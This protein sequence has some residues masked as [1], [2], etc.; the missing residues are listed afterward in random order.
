[1]EDRGVSIIALQEAFERVRFRLTL[2]VETQVVL[3]RSTERLI[4]FIEGVIEQFTHPPY[5]NLCKEYSK[6]R[7]DFQHSDKRLSLLPWP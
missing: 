5:S 3:Y 7:R 6:F 2:A 4:V 1:M